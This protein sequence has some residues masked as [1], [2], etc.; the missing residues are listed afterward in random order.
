MIASLAQSSGSDDVC[1]RQTGR[2]AGRQAGGYIC[3]KLLRV[4]TI[5]V[6]RTVSQKNRRK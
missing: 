4:R 5:F 3:L 1:P 2:Q 6:P